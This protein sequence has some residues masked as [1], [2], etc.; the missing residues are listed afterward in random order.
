[1]PGMMDTIFNLGL[2]DRT[3]EALAR[4]HRQRALR[5]GCLSPLH[6][7]V[8]QR[9]ARH[10]TR[11]LSRSSIDERKK[12]LGVANDPEVDAATWKQLGRAVQSD[13]PRA[14]RDATF[15]RTCASSCDCAIEAVFDSWHSKRA[16]DYR[17]YQQDS[18]RLGNGRHRDGDG[19]RQHGRRFGNRRR[20]HAQSRTPAN[21]CC[22]ASICSNAQ[23]EDVVAGIRTPEKIADLAQHAAGSVR[24]VSRDRRAASS[25]TIATCR[26]S[27]LPSS[28]ASSSCCRR[29]T[30]SARAEAAV[31][32]A[33]DLVNEGLID[34]APRRRDGAAR[35]SLD[36][37]FHA[38]IDPRRDG[39]AS[40]C[41]GLNASPGAAAGQ[42]VFSAD[43]A[44]A[45]KERRPK[46]DPRA[47]RDRRPTTCT[48]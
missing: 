32:I 12:T 42:V 14:T 44:V 40:S 48:A 2:N 6:R 46:D 9:R 27:S 30:P 34:Q 17:R 33:L 47:H 8:L 29:A 36:Q 11:P 16:I 35:Q 25:G 38:R 37:L 19:L 28:A 24:A 7:D 26:I 43:D 20:L 15:R 21:A 31:K 3:V 18:R 45:W 23:G 13:R 4:A 10:R 41:K 1:M 5:V 22:S 39:R